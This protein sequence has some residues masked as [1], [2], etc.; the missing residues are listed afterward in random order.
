[1]ARIL[2]TD[3]SSAAI[4]TTPPHFFR[5]DDSGSHLRLAE[6]FRSGGKTKILLDTVETSLQVVGMRVIE[7]M[8][9]SSVMMRKTLSVLSFLIAIPIVAQ[10]SD[11]PKVAAVVNGETITVQKLDQMYARM[12]AQMRQ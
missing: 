8:L 3:F 2:R 10:Q 11:A 4:R 9:V 1:M 12:S 5:S 6:L 7:V